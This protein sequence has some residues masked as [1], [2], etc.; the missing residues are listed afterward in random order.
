M[1]PKKIIDQFKDLSW[2]DLREW[3]GSK[4]VSRGRSYQQ[5]NRVSELA[6]FDSEALIAWVEGTDR[7]ATK[8][9][10]DEE[11]LPDSICTCPYGY[12]CK[13]GVAVVLEYLEQ[14]KRK[15]RIPQAKKND[16]RFSL[17]DDDDSDDDWGDDWDDESDDEPS[18]TVAIKTEIAAFLKGKTKSQLTELIQELAQKFPEMARE[19]TDRRQID[20]GDVKSLVK[21]LKKDIQDI[22]SEPDWDDYW[23]G[24]GSTPDYSGIRGKLETLLK[25]GH[26]DDVLELARELIELGNQ[27]VEQSHDD[28]DTAMEI[29][30]CMPII[31]KALEQSSWEKADQ[32]AWAVNV[33]LKDDYGILDAFGEFLNQRHAQADWNIL[34]DRLLKQLDKMK[35]SEGDDEFHR[36]YTRDQLSGWAIHAL[37]RAGRNDEIIPLCQVEAKKTGSYSRLVERL[38]YAKRYADA[39]NWI[40]QGIKATGEKLPG[41]ASS[42]R[43]K[44][45]GI[46]VHQKDWPVVATMQTENFVCYPSGITFTECHKAN[47]KT[48][49]WSKVRE[50]LLTYLEKGKLPWKQKGWPLPKSDMEST[51]ISRNYQYPIY[52]V[53]IRIAIL[54]KKPDRVIYWYDQML[55]KSK[56]VSF[57]E[58]EIA[59]VVK[60]YAPQR[61]VSIWKNLAESLINQVNVGAYERAAGYLRQAEKLMKRE[62]KQDE[63]NRYLNRLKKEH[64]RKRRLMQIL[65]ES[66]SQPII[67][68]R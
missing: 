52:D 8:V 17:F 4:I 44:L 68:K 10:M 13:H 38:I 32:L 56:W 20:S 55:K 67:K 15:Q 3:A 49:T 6:I 21:R 43:D 12:D 2:D 62:K 58:N 26:A 59:Q 57:D 36:D 33:V 19:L 64:A 31:V 25:T 16:E 54:E 23:Q 11:G 5:Q 9:T 66:N 37:E 45:Q 27:Q 63:W 50:Y 30:E 28:G 7:Y 42:L 35:C 24:G 48:K 53:L 65:D 51:S 14:I 61:S 22:S 46:R 41:I 29:E 18:L 40:Q 39:E 60:D 1:K 34:A 47:T